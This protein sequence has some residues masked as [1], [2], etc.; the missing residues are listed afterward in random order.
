MPKFAF[1]DIMRAAGTAALLM[2]YQQSRLL[3]SRKFEAHLR[4]RGLYLDLNKLW[5]LGILRPILVDGPI[6]GAFLEAG[7]RVLPATEDD[8]DHWVDASPTPAKISPEL[9]YDAQYAIDPERVWY[10]PMQVPHAYTISR[11][12]SERTDLTFLFTEQSFLKNGRAR[13]ERLRKNLERDLR[14][15]QTVDHY[16][17]AT[18]LISAFSLENFRVTRSLSFE[19]LKGESFEDYWQ[20]RDSHDSA[21]LQAAIS[22]QPSDLKRWHYD[23]SISASLLDP[24]NRWH[25]LLVIV[26]EDAWKLAGGVNLLAH[27]LRRAAQVTRLYA[28]DFL[29]LE[30]PEEEEERHGPA[31]TEIRRRRYGGAD[32]AISGRSVRRMVA[33]DFGVSGEATVLWFVEGPTETA[34]IEE[35]GGR[36]G[37]PCGAAGVSVIDLH[38][39]GTIESQ[40]VWDRLIEA[41]RE[42]QF[43]HVTLDGDEDHSQRLRSLRE[44]DLLTAGFEVLTGDFEWAN[45]GD[46]E[47]A[48]LLIA[49]GA[50]QTVELTI[51]AADVGSG[52]FTGISSEDMAKKLLRGSTVQFSK[53]E[54]WGRRLAIWATERRYAGPGDRPIVNTMLSMIQACSINYLENRRLF[55]CGEDGTM[56][57][58]TP[59]NPPAAPPIPGS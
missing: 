8:H 1:E 57:E 6:P 53:G 56:V 49:V 19:V 17:Q 18:F 39:L 51:T 43:A 26:D 44:R 2:P 40:H 42:Y 31:A 7:F 4:D 48:E 33:Q 24:L 41:E 28:R 29:D 47:L 55:R 23:L 14:D 15:W 36:T 30:L 34:F 46:Q 25:D 10:H 52:R 13:R 22:L 21:T 54:E 20:W 32:V 35:Y 9:S 3:E 38:G 37:L 59:T 5:Q 50:E 27:D 16:R 11:G 12:L 58:R 45:F